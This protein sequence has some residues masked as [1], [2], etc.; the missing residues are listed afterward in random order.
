[1]GI[2]VGVNP[3]KTPVTKGSHGIAQNTIPNICKMPG[4]PAPFVP[5]PLPNIAKSELNPQ[6]Y[7]TTVEI[8]GNAVAIRGATF[9]SIGDIAS[10]G[11]GG[12]LISANCQGP[13]KFIS[14]GSLTVQIEGK[15]VHQLTDMMLN[16]CG[17]GG[18]P[19]N[20]GATMCGGETQAD[21]PQ[22]KICDLEIDCSDKDPPYS[23]CQK[24]QLCK[25]VDEF[26]K[27]PNDQKDTVSPSPRGTK[28]YVNQLGEFKD[29]FASLVNAEPPDEE[30]IKSQFYDPGEPNKD[31]AYKEWVASGRPA[32]P[33]GRGPGK[34][35]PDHTHPVSHGG[36]LEGIAG[37]K[38]AD[39]R[40]NVTAGPA[41]RKYDNKEHTKMTASKCCG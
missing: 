21:A 6:G 19:P 25:M 40:I 36:S 33:S 16:N 13:A 23:E 29:N 12:G 38:W 20:T 3:P 24:A 9:E 2:S 30:K 1:V 32:N 41:M 26:N 34:F 39:A 37:M 17:P 7:S 31:C 5:T 27:I 22:E 8:E 28:P 10:K 35:N 14:P 15:N 11:T 18:S 4:P